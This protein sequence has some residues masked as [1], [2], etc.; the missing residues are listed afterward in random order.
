MTRLCAIALRGLGR[1]SEAASLNER[2]L[3][4]VR[5]TVGEDNE[6]WFGMIDNVAADRRTQGRFAEELA[7]R[8]TVHDRSGVTLGDNDPTTLRY[9]HDLASCHRLMGNFFQARDL[10][11][12]T[13]RHKMAVFGDDHQSTY[14][15]KSALAVDLRECGDYETARRHLLETLPRQEEVLGADHPHTIGTARNLAVT[16]R[17]LGDHGRALERS[18]DCVDAYRHRHGDRHVD[19]VT[20][21]A[22]FM[23]QALTQALHHASYRRA[24]GKRLIEQPLMRNVLADLALESEAATTLSL[25]IARGFDASAGDT[26]ERLF[27]RIATPVA[28]YWLNKRAPGHVV[29]ALECL[30][31]AGYVDQ[32]HEFVGGCL[33]QH[34]I[35]APLFFECL[36]GSLVVAPIGQL[37]PERR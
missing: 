6:I 9:A 27:S 30:G 3:E 5:E 18:R 33:R 29:E 14:R 8:K 20:A 15:S 25:R 26:A 7:L 28:K 31:G 10:D 19:T 24:F 32:H 37:Q 1:D 13:L 4:V 22:A 11:S 36:V 23:R 35:E 16:L 21:P 34:L 17:R 12:E 2:N